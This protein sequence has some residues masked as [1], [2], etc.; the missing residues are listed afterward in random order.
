[1]CRSA[2]SESPGHEGTTFAFEW[3]NRSGNDQSARQDEFL[4]RCTDHCARICE[5]TQG[6][7][8]GAR[9]KGTRPSTGRLVPFTNLRALAA[10]RVQHW[11]LVYGHCTNRHEPRSENQWTQKRQHPATTVIDQFDRAGAGLLAPERS[12]ESWVNDRARTSI[13]FH[14]CLADLPPARTYFMLSLSTGKAMYGA[15]RPPICY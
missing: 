13:S 11:R 14:D 7:L 10:D 4:G 5:W 8:E 12:N 15:K 2:R 6:A 3:T 1:V 9:T